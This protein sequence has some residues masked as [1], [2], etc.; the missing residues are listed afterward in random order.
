MTVNCL[1][2]N[3]IL[4]SKLD[5]FYIRSET[6]V[7]V[8]GHSIEHE[9]M[10]GSYFLR[11]YVKEGGSAFKGQK[12]DTTPPET[13]FRHWFSFNGVNQNPPRIYLREGH[14]HSKDPIYYRSKGH[15]EF[16][17]WIQYKME[18]ASL[19]ETRIS[20]WG[21]IRYSGSSFLKKPMSK[22]LY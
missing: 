8:V 18:S 17:D 3:H 20:V 9:Q 14:P 1:K 21:T 13:D 16:K 19:G 5:R 22:K 11:N 7:N 6:Q 2:L 10:M 4:T 15:M 12:V